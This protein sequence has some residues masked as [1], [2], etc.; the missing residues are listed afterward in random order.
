MARILIV[1]RSRDTRDVFA[2]LLEEERHT[3]MTAETPEQAIEL[4]REM[5]PDVVLIDPFDETKRVSDLVTRLREACAGAKIV[6][7]SESPPSIDVL[8]EAHSLGADLV[9]RKPVMP[10]D[11]VAAIAAVL[12]DAG[13]AA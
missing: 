8:A 1:D 9:L 2:L 4:C 10:D 11:L 12:S 6:V 7:F 13:P 3:T 5:P